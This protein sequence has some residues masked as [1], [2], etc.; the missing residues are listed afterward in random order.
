MRTLPPSSSY[1]VRVYQSDAATLIKI[2]NVKTSQTYEF[3]TYQAL[4]E[5]LQAKA[6][7]TG[8]R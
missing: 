8:L 1:I 2:Q 7:K 4:L 6:G 3:R 5:Y